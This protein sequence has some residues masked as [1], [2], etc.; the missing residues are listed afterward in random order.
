MNALCCNESLHTIKQHYDTK[1]ADV[2]DVI[3]WRHLRLDKIASL[4]K[5][6]TMSVSNF[7]KSHTESKLSVEPVMIVSVRISNQRKR[8][9]H[10]IGREKKMFN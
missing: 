5:K 1:R 4:M 7:K 3:Q 6:N 2:F 8:K 10:R 9:S